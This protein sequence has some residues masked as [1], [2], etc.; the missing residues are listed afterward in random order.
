[1]DR[2]LTRLGNRLGVGLYRRTNGRLVGYP[3]VDVLLLTVPGRRS[4]RSRAT[5]V[6]FLRTADGLLVWGTASGCPR[7][8]DWFRN[9]R[10]A[11]TAVVRIGRESV[12]V[13]AREL[14][15]PERDTAWRL[16]RQELPQVDRYARRSGRTI[17]VA[18]LRSG[19]DPVVDDQ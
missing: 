6:R 17:P 12:P 7:D 13:R 16:V 11:G 15:G 2:R 18:V 4:G 5:C 3:A 14:L 1:M 19:G 10:A 9:L 8:P